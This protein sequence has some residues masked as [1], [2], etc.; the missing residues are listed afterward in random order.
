[1]DAEFADLKIPFRCVASDLYSGRLVTLS[2]GKVATAVAASSSMPT[3]FPPVKMH[4]Q[5]LIDGGV[6]CRVPTEQ[7]REMGAD[8]VIAVD[9]LDNTK[10]SVKEVKN[11]VTM[12][13]RIFD[14]MDYNQTELQK[15]IYQNENEVWLVPEMKGIS[16]YSVKNFDETFNA[17]YETAKAKMPEIKELI[18]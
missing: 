11:I 8:A 5:L 13:M 10:D 14:M 1:G 12:I 7:C 4:G 6:L 18:K 2:E 17:G 16:Q 15:K 9:V 3:V